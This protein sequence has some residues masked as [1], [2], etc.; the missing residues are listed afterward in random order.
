MTRSVVS[1]AS[2]IAEGAERNSGTE[3][4]RFC[5]LL[6][7]QLQNYERKYILL[8]KLVFIRALKHLSLLM[9]S[10]KYLQCFKVL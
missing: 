3:Y 5:I 4:I 2:N 8:S 9:N 6:K 7:D 10:K 1:I